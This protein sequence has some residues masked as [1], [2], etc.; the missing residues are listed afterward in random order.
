MSTLQLIAAVKSEDLA[1]A[2]E[3]LQSGDDVNQQDE[4]GWTALNWAAGK[5][6]VD[7]VNLL[8]ENAADVFRV[9]RDQRT[10]Y[11]IALAAGHAAVTRILLEAEKRTGK[12]TSE[13]KREYCKAYSLSDLRRF[14]GWTESEINWKVDTESG[15]NSESAYERFSDEDIVFLHSDLTVTQSMWH[16]E[17]IIFNRITPEW[18]AFCIETLQFQVPTDL[19]LIAAPMTEASAA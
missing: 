13:S 15:A 7:G 14:S 16:N 2:K 10:P 3:L 11:K 9:G 12:P 8:L 6:W 5:G 17:N 19:D 1:K 4:Q 18:Q